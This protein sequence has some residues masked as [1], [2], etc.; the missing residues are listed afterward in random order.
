MCQ[1]WFNGGNSLN[2]VK[3][4]TLF[5][6]FMCLLIAVPAT[7]AA[8]DAGMNDTLAGS[9]EDVLAD[10]CYFD[11]NSDTDGNGT[12]DSPYN[13][14]TADRIKSGSDNHLASGEYNLT[15]DL[16]RSSISF[17]GAGAQNT[18][19]NGNGYTL[20]ADDLTL[21]NI[22]L[23][24]V[25][26]LSN[27]IFIISASNTVFKDTHADGRGG[28]ISSNYLA[29]MTFT[30]CT[31]SNNS[32]SY[33]GAIYVSRGSIDMFNCSFE[34]N[35]A[36]YGGAIYMGDVWLESHDSTFD[37]NNASMLGG[38][39]ASVSS[40]SLEL[41]NN[42]FSDNSAGFE[43]GAIYSFM[44]NSFIFA[45]SF[46]GNSANAGG[47]LFIDTNTDV[48][49]T[50]N[51]FRKNSAK[52]SAGAVYAL[53]NVNSNIENNIY[54]NNQAN[55]DKDL[56]ETDMPF[57]FV[58][59]GNY[60][61]YN[62]N[63]TYISALPSAYSLRDEGYVTPVKDQGSGGNCWAFAAMAAL[64][65]C[66]LK[67]SGLTYD[68]SEGNMKNLMALFS[69][70]GWDMEPNKGGYDK[71][72][73]GYLTGWLGP[74]N[75]TDDP[76]SP[77]STISLIMNSLM[78]VQNIVF[79]T[80]SNYMDNDDI[81][82]AIMDY[83]AVATSIA[84]YGQYRSGRNY[85][86][87]STSDT[88]DKVNH[89]VTIVG[90]DD[91][92]SKNNFPT[93]APGDGAWIIKNS[94]GTNSGD[95]GFYYVSYYDTKMAKPEKKSTTFTF[96]LNDT[97]KFDKNYQYDLPGRTDVFLNST[98]TVWYKNIFNATD[99]EYLA[100]VSTYFDDNTNWT[101]YV[102]VNGA[103]KLSQSG[104]SAESYSTI[105]LN[106]M[107]PLNVGDIF[108]IVFKIT[109]DGDAGVPISEK[110]S[111][112]HPFYKENISFISYDGETWTDLYN[113]V[114]SYPGHIY[115]SQV[116]CIKAFTVL[117]TINTT[118]TLTSELD[119][120]YKVITEVV[121]QYDRPV[122]EG[123]VVFNVN[124]EIFEIPVKKGVAIL[125]LYDRP[126]VYHI[127]A[128]YERSGY[129]ASTDNVTVDASLLNTSLTLS[130]G[131]HNP[132]N[133]TAHV[134]NEYGQPISCGNVTF[135]LD[136][137]EY[138][139]NVT[140][141]MATLIKT[142]EILENHNVSAVFNSI[143]YYD[144]SNV[145]QR[146]FNISLIDTTVEVAFDNELNPVVIWAYVVDQYGEMVSYGNV[147]FIVEGNDYTVNLTQ[148]SANLTHTFTD[149]GT[150][151]VRVIYNGL[152]IYSSSND[153]RQ[154]DVKSKSYI[155]LTVDDEF[156]PV[157]FTIRFYDD[158]NQ[159]IEHG[160]GRFIVEN[161]PYNFNI[162]NGSVSFTHSFANFG[163]NEFY[164]TLNAFDYYI[165]FDGV[166]N[167]TVTSRTA[168]N[169]TVISDYVPVGIEA[170]VF[171]EY[172]RTVS[173]GNVTFIVDDT[174]YDV[175]ITDG[176][177]FLS[178]SFKQIGM[179]RIHAIFNGIDYYNSSE[180][181]SDVNVKSTIIAED[182][183]KTLNSEYHFQL[184]DSKGIPLNNTNVTVNI[185][186]KDY[187]LTTDENGNAAL[188]ITFSP[189][190][191][192]ITITNPANG[193]VKTHTINVV[194][195]ITGNTDIS[196]YYGAGKVYNVRAFD[197]NGNAIGGVKVTFK[198]N[199]KTYTGTTDA[200]GY[201]SF[202]ISQKPGKYTIT[203]EYKGFKVSNKVTVKNTLV[204]KNISL[205]K[206]KTIKFTAK[207]LNK[208]GKVVKGKKIKFK[209][210]GK[211]YYKK[212]NRKGIATLKITKKYRPGK[213]T[214]TTSYGSLKVKNTIK[215]K[216]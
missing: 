7:F 210:K 168:L 90:W 72:G 19:L 113:L 195:R 56:Y 52:Y 27:D 12:A 174:R 20:T 130:I 80:R 93:H 99:N 33:G 87:T 179:N 60:L 17:I 91:N 212:T 142:F 89:A 162:E 84:W 109:V 128:S 58:G 41:N 141:G 28:A 50:G 73:V 42:S 138:V 149:F 67:A 26:I 161:V 15:S 21:S 160:S 1:N 102:Y 180:I 201:V 96:I 194:K 13:N 18:T 24:N 104:F 54:E 108:E 155:Q 192:S 120:G 55:S 185:N 85:Y 133:I 101:V 48:N 203:A 154:V 169:L 175:N 100:A 196:M 4:V 198:I 116:A 134:V 177:A 193:E 207:L 150:N 167:I 164:V 105:N 153:E 68:L 39:I 114:W 125:D 95:K 64:E 2:R 200:S 170:Q 78:H 3:F 43:G 159:T 81:K 127:T 86:C 137:E 47:A 124:G 16:Y 148:G 139:V 92:Y 11:V 165:A 173:S 208:N 97:I 205:K 214:I 190:T 29:T 181:Y 184:L 40:R 23:K 9:V 77:S 103:L 82:R 186:S 45:S 22:T 111:L 106:E 57:S 197:D 76:Y 79:L 202:K 171:D 30:N 44:G 51:R 188:D 213:Y 5:T 37:N 6:I 63:S 146:E 140:D 10:D 176:K 191:Y 83:G 69:D 53:A 94:W 143:Y 75:E 166:T 34:N 119:G 183:T 156:N 32:A 70:Y 25:R 117:D 145:D 61:M 132:A 172:G 31:F 115:K 66:I 59:D 123:N 206:G 38:A 98:S 211:T 136:G 71:M 8:D 14:F 178:Y 204:T 49:I 88:D 135:I 215:I 131:R 122:D 36:I 147:T 35:S 216:K 182:A 209:F 199:G 163:L 144:T 118:L 151:R 46:T 129:V 112:V 157:N 126:N 121:N 187:N 110:E 107:I 65:S 62:Y 74:I 158:H 189:A 152:N